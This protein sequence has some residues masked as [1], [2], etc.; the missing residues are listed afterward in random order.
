MAAVITRSNHPDALWPGV[1]EWFGLNYDEF[2]DI[3][4]EFAKK[5]WDGKRPLPAPPSGD[6][7]RAAE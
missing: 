6:R 1:L 5:G 3:W 2:P 7:R 4:S